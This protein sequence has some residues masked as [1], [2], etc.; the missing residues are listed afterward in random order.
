MHSD[1]TAT[2]PTPPLVLERLPSGEHAWL[3]PRNRLD[4]VRYTIT[5]AGRRAL[6]EAEQADATEA[7]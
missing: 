7:G 5:E 4:D 1:S 6:R 3:R 2:Q